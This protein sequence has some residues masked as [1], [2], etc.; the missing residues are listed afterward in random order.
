MTA[1]FD[2]HNKPGMLEGMLR[3]IP[4]FAGYL[5]KDERRQSDE[6]A[7][8][9]VADRL[10]RAKR[11]LDAFTRGLL[12]L[13]QIDVLPKFD[14]LRGR[15]DYLIAQLRSTRPATPI[16]LN[17]PRLTRI[18]WK[19][20][21]NMTSGRSK[22]PRNSPR[23]SS[24]TFSGNLTRNNY[25]ATWADASISLNVG[26]ANA[27]SCWPNLESRIDSRLVVGRMSCCLRT[28]TV[29]SSGRS[30]LQIE[31]EGLVVL[32]PDRRHEAAAVVE[33]VTLGNQQLS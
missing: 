6:Q 14:R 21:T 5:D 15:I 2:D 20:F 3:K 32:F 25:C 33:R 16:S 18:G 4:G 17:R 27:R 19:T 8:R 24:P 11:S 7:R 12:E 28:A 1:P 23:K 10:D 26:F 29:M 22:R 13:G 31:H 30:V 9:W